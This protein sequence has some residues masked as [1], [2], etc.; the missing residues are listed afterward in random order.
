[1]INRR[2]YQ[3]RR[4]PR[5]A[6]DWPV[7]VVND[8]STVRGRVRNISR[9]GALLYLSQELQ[10]KQNIRVAIE[11]QE[12]DDVIST[13]A[14]V[15]RTFRVTADS[16]GYVFAAG[17]QFIN[18][19][20]ENLK[21]FTGNLAPEWQEDYKD[22]SN[23]K[24]RGKLNFIMVGI[25]VAAIF[26]LSSS[27]FLLKSTDKENDELNRIENLEQKIKSLELENIAL[28]G[29]VKDNEEELNNFKNSFDSELKFLTSNNF[30]Q[31]EKIVIL[32]KKFEDFYKKFNGEVDDESK[33]IVEIN[34]I[35][36]V[37]PEKQKKNNYYYTVKKGDNLFRIAKK[38]SISVDYLK[39]LNNISDSD[40][41]YPSQR[42]L[43]N[44]GSVATVNQ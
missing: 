27:F 9:D 35:E 37:G 2:K 5:A 6:K 21:Y 23:D 43:V 28:S 24:K 8:H 31:Q 33:N 32:N 15:V 34:E 41:I 13:E 36:E 38:Y 16:A 44:K 10:Y 25:A 39:K 29:I 14:E 12:Y 40:S 3:R 7:T 11:I 17:I 19:S 18:I 30:D 22:A 20:K 4:S 1:M 26:M 42:L